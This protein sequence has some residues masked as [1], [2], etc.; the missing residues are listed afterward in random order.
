MINLNDVIELDFFSASP[1]FDENQTYY[2][3]NLSKCE[4]YDM[5]KL[6][7]RKK[8]RFLENILKIMFI[9]EEDWDLSWS[10]GKWRMH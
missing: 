3:W 1:D 6:Q 10:K 7:F 2:V 4:K 8:E 5:K 9:I